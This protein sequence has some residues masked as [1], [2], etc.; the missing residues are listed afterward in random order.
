[1]LFFDPLFLLFMLP[2]LALS[3]WATFEVRSTFK[4]YSAVLSASGMTGAQ[5]AQLLVQR[6]GAPG[7]QIEQVPGTLSDHYDPGRRVLRLSSG[8]YRNSSVA[9]LGV[10]AHEAG[11]AIQHAES[12]WPMRVRSLI[13]KPASVGSNLG[14][15]LAALG[16]L[17]NSA[18]LLWL[19]TL[20]FGAFVLF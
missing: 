11:H 5:T 12:Y 10:A 1:M 6:Y 19:G 7:V 17:I 8:V 4:R 16:L 9:A 14:I 18:G 3:L 13:V 15:V 20:L 2:G